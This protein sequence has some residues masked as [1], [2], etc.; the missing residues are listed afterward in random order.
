MGPTEVAVFTEVEEVE[1]EESPEGAMD[2]RVE[3]QEEGRA[4]VVRGKRQER[5]EHEQG[6]GKAHNDEGDEYHLKKIGGGWEGGL[7][8]EKTEGAPSLFPRDIMIPK[9]KPTE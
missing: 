7:T 5:E 6:R 1:E 8:L 2:G 3:G 9:R 4:D